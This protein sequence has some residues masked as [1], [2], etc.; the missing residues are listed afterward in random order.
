MRNAKHWSESFSTAWMAGWVGAHMHK[1]IIK[2]ETKRVF[3]AWTAPR[4]DK[5]CK[6]RAGHLI[7][8]PYHKTKHV[9]CF[10]TPNRLIINNVWGRRGYCARSPSRV[11]H[12]YRIHHSKRAHTQHTTH[13]S[14]LHVLLRPAC[15][16]LNAAFSTGRTLNRIKTMMKSN[17]MT[18]ENIVKYN[19]LNG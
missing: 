3:W 9:A 7:S 1:I 4:D 19:T 8:H 13:F 18:N 17:K 14:S 15:F 11:I 2:S 6:S 10:H 5:G 16:Q 12:S